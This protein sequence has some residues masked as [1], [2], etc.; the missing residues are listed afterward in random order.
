MWLVFIE[1]I[2]SLGEERDI[3]LLSITRNPER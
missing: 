3:F 1:L 2:T